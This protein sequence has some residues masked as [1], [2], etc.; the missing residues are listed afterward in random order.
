V[1]PCRQRAQRNRNQHG[2]DQREGRERE[3]RLEALGDQR[4]DIDAEVE[5][6][7]KVARKDLPEPDAELHRDRPVEPQACADLLDLLGVSRVARQNRRGIPRREAK[8][9]EYQDRDDQ[10]NG[11]RRRQPP[12]NEIDQFFFKFQ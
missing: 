11:D 6:L 3:R 5:R 1:A 7:A 8:Q 9:Q 10:Q 12:G 4:R 2:D